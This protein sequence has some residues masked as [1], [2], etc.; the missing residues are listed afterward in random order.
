M[1]Y[2]YCSYFDLHI[3]IDHKYQLHEFK[4]THILGTYKIHFFFTWDLTNIAS[5]HETQILHIDSQTNTV[6]HR[7]EHTQHSLYEVVTHEYWPYTN[8][9]DTHNLTPWKLFCGR[10]NGNVCFRNQHPNSFW[11]FIKSSWNCRSNVKSYINLTL[12][13]YKIAKRKGN[14]TTF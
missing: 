14:C 3:F 11:S 2:K 10:S 8:Y 1:I 7:M 4:L 9:Q 6:S 5:S 12:K 13:K